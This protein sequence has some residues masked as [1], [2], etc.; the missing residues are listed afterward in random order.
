M[1]YYY[2]VQR[3][4]RELRVGD[5]IDFLGHLYAITHFEPHPGLTEGGEHHPGRVAVVDAGWGITVLDD[6]D[7]TALDSQTEHDRPTCPCDRCRLWRAVS[8]L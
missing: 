3:L 2:R 6:E 1:P 4:G 5:S 7:V 8:K